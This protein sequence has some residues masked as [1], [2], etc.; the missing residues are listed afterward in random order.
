[1]EGVISLLQGPGPRLGDWESHPG[2]FPSSL[3]HLIPHLR[4]AGPQERADAESRPVG[5]HEQGGGIGPGHQ[6][7]EGS[8]V[9]R[10][11]AHRKAQ[12][13]QVQQWP[14]PTPTQT[15]TYP[16]RRQHRAVPHPGEKSPT[17]APKPHTAQ[18]RKLSLKK[19][20][21]PRGLQKG[22][23]GR[24]EPGF[25]DCLHQERSLGLGSFHSR[26]E[27]PE[28]NTQGLGALP[29]CRITPEGRD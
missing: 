26:S 18:Y 22:G 10:W 25:H 19:P 8:L 4:E 29:P 20:Y 3:R 27:A 5:H 17:L 11:G 7:Q 21:T 13:P 16:W 1:M 28:M 23:L 12:T 14:T 6:H 2:V 15:G 9:P 24:L